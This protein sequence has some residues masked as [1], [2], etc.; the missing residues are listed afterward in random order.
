MLSGMTIDGHCHLW[1]P[2][3]GF[4]IKPI[5]EH[6]AFQRDYLIP[7][8]V[9]LCATCGIDHVVVTQSAPQSE[10]TRVLL[11]TCRDV[12]LVSGV[13]GWVDLAARNI[14]EVL[15]ELAREPKFVGIRAQLRRIPDAEFI[16]TPA[17]RHG[18]A[19]VARRGLSAVL[20]A[21]ERHHPHCLSVLEEEPSL[22]AVLNHG[23]MPDLVRGD[24]ASWRRNMAAYADR[25]TVAVQL[26]GFVSLAGPRW[27]PALVELVIGHLLDLFGAD[28]LM[29]ASDWPMTDLDAS[30]EA[31]WDVIGTALD[32][33]HLTSEEKSAIFA[34]TAIRVHRLDRPGR[35]MRPGVNDTQGEMQHSGGS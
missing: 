7:Q 1:S 22:I 14:D 20:L 15:D 16:A 18:L 29:F 26:S 5:R 24:M 33:L 4:D 32:R 34:G 11:D 2:G 8:L 27:S 30:Y 28:R 12:P 3:R 9:P 35:L 19:A 10:E 31:W 17:A 21:E 6:V 23:G 13:T 25:T